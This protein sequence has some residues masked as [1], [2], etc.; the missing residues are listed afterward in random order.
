MGKHLLLSFFILFISI[1]P[2]YAQQ[3]RINE[4]MSSNTH[5]LLDEDR[6]FSDW[7]ELIN[8]SSQTINLSGYYLTDNINKPTQ[9]Q[10]PNIQ[11]QS[12]EFLLVFASGKDKKN[13]PTHWKVLIDQGDNW[14]YTVPQQNITGW[15]TTEFDDYS[16]QNGP[17][18]IGYGDN[19]DATVIESLHSI[20]M[21]KE[22]TIDDPSQIL[23][24]I[25]S[26]DYDDGFVAYLNGT[27][28]ARANLGTVGIPPAYN[29]YA[30]EDHEASLYRG[31]SPEQFNIAS[32][33]NIIKPGTNLLAIQVHN[34][35]RLSSDFSAIPFLSIRTKEL[36]E[37]FAPT[38]LKLAGTNLHTSFKLD[39][40]GESLFLFNSNGQK[41]DEMILPRLPSDIS[42][43]FK[44]GNFNQPLVFAEPTPWRANNSPSLLYDENLNPSFSQEGGILDGTI[45]LIL[46]SKNDQDIIYYT[47]DGSE[48]DLNSLYYVTPINISELTTIRAR[49]IRSGY[50]PG[51]IITHSYLPSYDKSLPVVLVSTNYDNLWDYHTGIYIKG[52]NASSTSPY[53]GANF[54]Q[55]WE[56]PAHIELYFPSGKTGFSIDG[57]IKIFGNY[58][59]AYDQKSLAVFARSKYGSKSITCKLFDNKP[60]EKFESIVLRTGGTDNFAEDPN[61][62]TK[63]RDRFIAKIG[64]QMNLDAQDGFPCVVYLNGE[65]WGIYNVRE[66]VNEHF[67]ADNNNISSENINLLEKDSEIIT[68]SNEHYREMMSFIN[69]NN[70]AVESNYE[71][72]RTR[73]DI[74]NYI[75]YNVIELF[76]YNDD[77]PGN[78][79]KYWRDGRETSTW[80]WILFDVDTGFGL[81]YNSFV[82]TNSITIALEP[83][84]PSWPNPPWSTILLR[85][86]IQNETFKTR[87]INTF[88]DHMNTTLLPEKTIP[89]AESFANQI[90]DE[91]EP[92]TLRWGSYYE[93]WRHNLKKIYNFA[94]KRPTSM[95]KIILDQFA[96]ADT[97]DVKLNIQGCDLAEIQINTIKINQFPWNGIY[98]NQIP[99]ELTATAPAGY[100]FSRWE[101]DLEST[102]VKIQVPMVSDMNLTAVFEE[103]DQQ[104]TIV[105][106]EIMYNP[107]NEFDSGD[108]VELYNNSSSY[109]NLTNWILKDSDDTN[110]YRFAPNTIMEPHA[111]LV[112][113]RDQDAFSAVY[114]GVSNFQG[115]LGFGFSS[116]GECIRL[117]NNNSELVDQVCYASEYPWPTEP[118]GGGYTLE[119]KDPDADNSLAHNWFTSLT[120]N[121]T[122]GK[123]N[124]VGEQDDPDQPTDEPAESLLLQ[125][126][127]NPFTGSTRIPVYAHTNQLV[128]I[129]VYT[130]QG[131]LVTTIFNGNLSEG[132]HT[133]EWNA[134]SLR[135]GVYLIR[136]TGPSHSQV[137]KAICHQ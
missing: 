59:R 78:N 115:P 110:S 26:M 81:W 32:F 25:L 64:L 108:W 47:T 56:K 18:G 135:S 125:N 68:G 76:S 23:E 67:L 116:A 8:T 15:Y 65:Y 120:K 98:F 95:R 29:A 121:G 134:P 119:L 33:A 66:K 16:W 45:N 128:N 27:E 6:E 96:I 82:N 28:V 40:D 54:W 48:P 97:Q 103:D 10:F 92:H 57:G 111:Y 100:K 79:I 37:K 132:Y 94:D 62:G 46:S 113:C 86:L 51:Q 106:N 87:F 112:V 80:R 36:P 127:P 73:M 20:F 71:Y 131:Q 9:W 50:Y 102:E 124:T 22:F 126:Y 44:P 49:I 60:I 109:I 123:A 53:K 2:G 89:L 118:N 105:I 1:F 42:I 117:Y 70:I 85:S 24:M 77:W 104:G 17:T 39:S 31:L 52:P 129:S 83:N 107:S 3:L 12:G 101:G 43:G 11:L 58:S 72:L 114:P 91:I 21:R 55:D 38:F 137:K 63:I 88:A 69:N 41:T 130:L 74:D 99:I 4:V 5:T 14:K 84:G 122:P 90:D 61:W 93:I 13:I 75:R 7:I 133:F 30:N 34:N 136:Y 19:D 35:Y